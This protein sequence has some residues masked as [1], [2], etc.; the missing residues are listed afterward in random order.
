MI[1]VGWLKNS[2]MKYPDFPKAEVTAVVNDL[3]CDLPKLCPG[4]SCDRYAED[5]A[6]EYVSTTGIRVPGDVLTLHVSRPNKER[7]INIYIRTIELW[8]NGHKRLNYNDLPEELKTHNN[9]SS[10][11]DRFKV[12][13]GDESC[14]HTMLAHISKDGHYFIHPDIAQHQ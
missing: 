9:R 8:N 6:S 11:L 12:V 4:E 10:F 7:D 13:E 3:F 5:A 1:I 14:C 2:N